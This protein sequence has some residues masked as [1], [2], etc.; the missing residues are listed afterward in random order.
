[1]THIF[2]MAYDVFICYL[3]SGG[4]RYAS[5]Y[6]SIY[7]S[8]WNRARKDVKIKDWSQHS[9]VLSGL[10]DSQRIA[11]ENLDR[12]VMISTELSAM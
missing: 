11:T 8:C 9:T 3:G 5:G 10:H 1:M 2:G 12:T 4:H 6:I 7:Y